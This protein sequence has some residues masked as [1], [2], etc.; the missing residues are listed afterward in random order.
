LLLDA[1][2]AVLGRLW[3]GLSSRSRLR[4]ISGSLAPELFDD[5]ARA[6]KTRKRQF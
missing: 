6:S 5:D 3:L 2:Q 1:R 4:V